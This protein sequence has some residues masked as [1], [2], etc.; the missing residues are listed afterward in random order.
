MVTESIIRDFVQ[1]KTLAVVGVSRSKKKFSYQLYQALRSKGYR[2]FA[3][4]PNASDL[5]GEKCF[6][7]LQT[8]PEP[9]DGV[10]VITPPKR[11]ASIIK[12]AAAAGITRI[13]IQQ[14][15]ESPEAIAFCTENN[16]TVIHNQCL[17]MF[18]EPVNF[19]HSLHRCIWK[20]L[21]KI[22]K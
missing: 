21:G 6:A 15:A 12:K 9:V 20:I 18:A 11:T 16:L 17:L 4:N 13:W 22:P 5:D 14:G 3:V 7:G 1:Q 10:V 19:P 2:L 8:L